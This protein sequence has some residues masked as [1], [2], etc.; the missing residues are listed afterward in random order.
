M[1][2]LR[3]FAY[4]E[5]STLAEAIEIL[6]DQGSRAVPLAGGT[7]LLVRMKRGEIHPP[8]LVNLKRIEGLREI[9]KGSVRSYS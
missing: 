9:K 2:K 3:P 7:D 4:F 1:K 6:K 5:P 8:G